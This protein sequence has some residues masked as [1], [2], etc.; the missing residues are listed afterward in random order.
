MCFLRYFYPLIVI[1]VST[2][3]E[4]SGSSNVINMKK[5]TDKMPVFV[6][7]IPNV[8][9]ALGRDANIPC[10][11]NELG[12]YRAAWIRVETKAILTIHQH[13]ITR[14]Y[15]I[16]LSHSDNRNFILHIKDV[17]ESDRG[18]YM[19][20]INTVPMISQV[21]YLDV[22]DII[23][24][25]STSD[26]ITREGTNVTLKCKA[27]GYPEPSISWRRE[28]DEPIPLILGIGKKLI[29]SSY[30][31]ESLNITRVTRV[32]MGAYLCIASNGVPPSVSRRVLLH[33]QFPPVLWVPNQLVGA[34]VGEIASL[35]CHSEAYP[36]SIN[37]WKKTG[38]EVILSNKKF[39]VS[40]KEKSYKVHM[41]LSIR[42]LEKED[43]GTY[44]C[45]AKNSLGSTQGSIRL[46]EIPVPTSISNHEAGNFKHM[47]GD[48]LKH[49]SR[50]S[51]KSSRGF[52][53]E[54][55]PPSVEATIENSA[56]TRRSMT[57]LLTICFVIMNIC[58]CTVI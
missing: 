55:D 54:K 51:A 56:E 34:H 45:F 2:S 4:K 35:D 1:L 41:R 38:S 12:A 9:M 39:E 43:F 18:G 24:D 36:V 26:I 53:L 3:I 6:G 29:S 50:G 30:E 17:K 23:V 48:F 15:R 37:F 47:N 20:Q 22:L 44:S 11:V 7:P 49:Q 21:G 52:G 14:N 25:Q 33:V 19:C 40:S 5:E 31:G 16:S 57:S 27:K 28:D 46:Y 8:T 42:N 58:V 13:V 32:H 10:L